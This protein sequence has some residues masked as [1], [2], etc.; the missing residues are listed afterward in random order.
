MAYTYGREMDLV[1]YF[2]MNKN[3]LP[4]LCI[5]TGGIYGETRFDDFASDQVCI[6]Y[7][8]VTEIL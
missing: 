2:N 5:I 4:Q 8:Q 3:L 1:E 7:T 6:V